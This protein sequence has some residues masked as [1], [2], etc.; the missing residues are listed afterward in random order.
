MTERGKYSIELHVVGDGRT[1]LNFWDYVHGNDVCVQ[2]V[3][4]SL[5]DE[6]EEVPFDEFLKRVFESIEK[7]TL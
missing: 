3:D 5:Y 2:V 6:E 7:R 4:G 1:F